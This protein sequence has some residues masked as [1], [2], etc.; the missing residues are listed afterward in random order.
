MKKFIT[1][2]AMLAVA[3]SAHADSQY[4]QLTNLPTLYIETENSVEIPSKHDPY[5]RATL[6]L[7]DGDNV[8]VYDALGVRGRGNSTW[9]LPKKPYRIKFDKKQKFLGD[10]HANAKSWTLLA[11]HADKT[12][13][14]NAV[15]AYIGRLA[16]Q[17]FTAAAEFVD[18]VINGSYQGNYQISDQ[19]E[20][21]PKRVDIVEQSEPATA[22]SNITGGYF[23]EVDGFAYEE[24]VYFV[25][26]RGVAITIKSPDEDVINK[27]QKYYIQ[28]YI[29]QFE[30]A[31]FAANFTDPEKGYRRYV[32]EA[33]LASWYISSE[34]TGNVDAF[35]STYIYKNQDDPKIYWGPLWDYDIAFNN[36]NRTGEVTNSLMT[37]KGF[38]DDLT[39]KWIN[40]MWQDPWF[41]ALIN[42][43]W[44][45]LVD[46][47]IEQQIL[48]YIDSL[49]AHLDRSQAL[50]FSKWSISERAYNEIALFNTYSEG[51]DYLKNFISAHTAYL[52]T[53]FARA[54]TSLTPPQPF[55]SDPDYYYTIA[56]RGCLSLADV[57]THGDICIW[58]TDPARDSRHWRIIPDGEG[59]YTIINRVDNRAISDPAV[60]SGSGYAIGSQLALATPDNSDSR[61]KWTIVPAAADK[62]MGYIITNRLTGLA[63]NNSG[64]NS[65]DGNSIISWTSDSNNP[66][67][68]TRQWYIDKA[69]PAEAGIDGITAD[70]STAP[71]RYFNL[72]GREI[73]N[74]G[75]GIYIVRRGT[76]TYKEIIK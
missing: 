8:T 67:K 17:P 29:N 70:D 63:W 75:P 66:S 71:A 64:G 44:R 4:P 7:V 51:V 19:M 24:D 46:N 28:K 73:L 41:A 53:A 52:T 61:Q 11:N 18:L 45:Q 6:H 59:Y 72:T 16:G 23:L 62:G 42:D 3:V 34:L 49:A 55:E 36:C 2:I 40:R 25:T 69:Q 12:L 68:L 27:D 1:G 33:T 22:E 48:D 76:R 13:M 58:H 43:T 47:G 37:E 57:N 32:D 65:N 10:D 15:A 54:A 31:L 38:G 30:S 21:R 50:N 60:K 26:N 74:P 35:W 14:R 5:V 9:T 39:K 56:N 20:I